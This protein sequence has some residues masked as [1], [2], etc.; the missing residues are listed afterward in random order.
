MNKYQK[1]LINK[2]EPYI[3]GTFFNA[4]YII[5]GGVRYNGFWGKS[6]TFNKIYVVCEDYKNKKF[7]LLGDKY[8]ID[9]IDLCGL[10]LNADVPAKLN[11]LRF[12][13][14]LYSH[15]LVIREIISAPAIEEV[16]V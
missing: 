13:S 8:Q 16:K 10:H 5:P 1:E 15:K 11:C 6:E 7:Y 3:A 14:I 12:Y 4:F 2:C 9:I